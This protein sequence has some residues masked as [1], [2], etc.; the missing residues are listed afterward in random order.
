MLIE[1]QITKVLAVKKFFY[2]DDI[3]FCH[4]NEVKFDPIEGMKVMYT[5]S[6]NQDEKSN[7]YGKHIAIDVKKIIVPGDE[8]LTTEASSQKLTKDDLEIQEFFSSDK[9][10]PYYLISDLHDDNH[11]NVKE[12]GESLSKDATAPYP[13]ENKV[14]KA[15]SITQV[16][17]FYHKFLQI[18][19]KEAD[20]KQKKISLLMLK[21]NIEYSAKR[22]K[23]PRFAIMM[24]NR[25]NIVVRSN[26]DDFEENIEAFNRNFEALVAYYPT[27][28]EETRDEE[29]EF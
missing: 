29:K 5:Q 20:I 1:G 18:Y 10:I 3:Y 9:T 21:A 26:E 22:M 16:R 2:I 7:N 28:E 4:F 6:K 25:I 12:I 17:N 24:H 13:G 8:V 11:K 19:Q 23:T 15:L 27:K 14:D